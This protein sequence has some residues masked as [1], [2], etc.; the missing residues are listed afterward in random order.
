MTAPT[1]PAVPPLPSQVGQPAPAPAPAPPLAPAPA[2][3]P[4]PSGGDAGSI[5]NLEA[6]LER[7]RSR[8]REFER[9]IA[10]LRQGQMT[11]QERA[12]AE[13]R[14]E[15]RKDAAKT[16]GLMLAAAEFRALAIGKLA[17]PGKMLD[18]GDLN[19]ARFVDDAGNID[20]RALARL[21]ERLAQAAAPA[22]NGPGVPAGPRGATPG[23]DFLRGVLK[24]GPK[25]W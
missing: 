13:A 4:A 23:D 18:D 21:V 16:T 8:T 17:D 12:V 9:Q 14:E 1:E 10:Q 6:A 2:P 22:V 7:E 5:A 11:D 24:G 3:A 20:K 25:G 19:L 15:G